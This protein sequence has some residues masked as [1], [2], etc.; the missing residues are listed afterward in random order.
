M[1]NKR[2][3]QRKAAEVSPGVQ[4]QAAIG[5]DPSVWSVSVGYGKGFLSGRRSATVRVRHLPSGRERSGSVVG[6]GKTATRR[7]AAEVARRLMRELV[8]AG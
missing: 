6:A 4:L 5:A 2:S 8:A 3:R 7:E 1:G